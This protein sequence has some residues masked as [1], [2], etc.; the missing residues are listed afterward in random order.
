[1]DLKEM[2]WEGGPAFI[3]LGEDH[4]QTLVNMVVNLQA[5]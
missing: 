2:K 5:A 4:W 1:M 3:W